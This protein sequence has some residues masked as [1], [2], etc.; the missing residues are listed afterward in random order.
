MTGSLG[1]DSEVCKLVQGTV[2]ML[3]LGAMG[4]TGSL[5]S[6]LFNDNSTL[7]QVCASCRLVSFFVCLLICQLCAMIS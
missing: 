7:Y 3:Q 2:E 1:D 6:C 5:P 4:L